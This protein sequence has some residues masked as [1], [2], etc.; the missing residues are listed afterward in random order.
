MVEATSSGAAN[1]KKRYDSGMMDA[2]VV[3]QLVP[4]GI[5]AQ[6]EG[7]LIWHGG[8]IATPQMTFVSVVI[9]HSAEQPSFDREWLRNND[10][11]NIIVASIV[12]RESEKGVIPLVHGSTSGTTPIMGLRYVQQ[13]LGP[14]AYTLEIRV[15]LSGETFDSHYRFDN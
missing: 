13:G 14:G 10:M 7:L 5:V 9:E 15:A 2:Q 8:L 4:P 11:R 12:D 6:A 3:S 1:G